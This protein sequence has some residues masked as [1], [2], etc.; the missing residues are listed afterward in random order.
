MFSRLR[1][2]LI[3]GRVS[4]LPTVWSNCF[5]GWWLGGGQNLAK[6]PG[7]FAG[8]T[9]L[10][11]GGMFLND[12]FDAE[13]DHAHRKDRPIPAGKISRK[14]VTQFG[15]AWLVSGFVIS[16]LLGKVTAILAGI[17]V[18]L[19]VIYDAI[20]KSTDAAPVLMGACRLALYLVAASCGVDGVTGFS[21]WCGI[22]MMA[23]IVGL[24]FVARAE[25][26]PGALKF[27]PII[28]LV[29]PI[30][31]ALLM[32]AEGFLKNA[33]VLSA[34]LGLWMLSSLRFIFFE[35]QRNIG[36]AVT[37]L[38]AG[39]ILVDMLAVPDF[40]FAYIWIF[41]ILFALALIFQRVIPA[42]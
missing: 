21:V 8:A 18:L 32:N 9:F 38:L 26:I 20:H 24:S 35:A 23:Y 4:N 3:L 11:I 13:F 14:T 41:P 28:L 37:R 36:K 5:V 39:I 6:L 10:Y 15:I 42:T 16:M 31:A 33:I 40:L 29:V 25:A 30:I 17:L 7:L 2:L 34:I 12:A 1:T 19:I 27:W 22:A